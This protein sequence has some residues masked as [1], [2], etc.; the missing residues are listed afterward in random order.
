M[1][2]SGRSG[3]GNNMWRS[4]LPF[5]FQSRYLLLFLSSSLCFLIRFSANHVNFV[6]RGGEV[7]PWVSGRVPCFL[8]SK[9]L[10]KLPSKFGVKCF[11]SFP[12]WFNEEI[13]CWMEMSLCFALGFLFLVSE[14]LLRKM[15]QLTLQFNGWKYGDNGDTRLANSFDS[16]TKFAIPFNF[17]R[18]RS[19][20]VGCFIYIYALLSIRAADCSGKKFN[21]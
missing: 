15:C 3:L 10:S 2:V 7:L 1:V 9:E 20:W 12:H 4:P 18:Q 8:L 14:N 19:K 17:T 16:L 5:F 21:S 13:E 11:S 6:S